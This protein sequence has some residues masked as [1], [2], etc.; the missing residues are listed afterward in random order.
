MQEIQETRIWSPGRDDPLEKEMATHSNILAGGPIDRGAWWA[1]VHGVAK[2]RMWLSNWTHS[3]VGVECATAPSLLSYPLAR[4]YFIRSP[5][6]GHSK[7]EKAEA[8]RPSV[9]LT[10]GRATSAEELPELSSPGSS[11]SPSES[12]LVHFQIPG[13]CRLCL[14][15]PQVILAFT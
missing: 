7:G 15:V 3:S 11:H 13:T 9:L 12:I 2:S 6:F 5:W 10:H 1:T 4:L 14:T 8:Q